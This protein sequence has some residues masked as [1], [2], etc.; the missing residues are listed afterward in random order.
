MEYEELVEKFKQRFDADKHIVRD[1]A[2][3]KGLP[4]SILSQFDNFHKKSKFY[5]Y[6]PISVKPNICF[7]ALEPNYG[8]NITYNQDM[9][10]YPFTG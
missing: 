6:K 2:S 1:I 10:Y 4:K 3:K 9:F 8:T 7:V 5:E